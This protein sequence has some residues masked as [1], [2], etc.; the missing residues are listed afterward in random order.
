MAWLIKIGLW[1]MFINYYPYNIMFGRFIPYG[2]YIFFGLIVIGILGSGRIRLDKTIKS[3]ILY[4]VASLITSVF[5]LSTGFAIES[6]VDFGIKIIV[7]YAVAHVCVREKSV[8]FAIRLLAGIA[9]LSAGAAY[10]QMGDIE[11]RLQLASGAAISINDFGSLMAYGCFAVIPLF[12]YSK[13]KSRFTIQCL[14]V[15]A[16]LLLVIEL[17]ISG[18]RKS[19]YA[20]IIL[21]LLLLVT[22][23]SKSKNRFDP[24]L[25]IGSMVLIAAVYLIYSNYLEQYVTQT[26]LYARILGEKAA[27]AEQSNEGRI[28]L[29]L[30]AWDDFKEHPIFGLGFRNFEYKHHIYTHSM[31]A[32]PLACSGLL[33]LLYLIPIFSMLKKQFNYATDKSQD[34]D[35]QVWNMELLAFYVV[36]L[37]IGIGIPYLYKEIPCIGFGLMIGWQQIRENEL[38]NS[39]E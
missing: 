13:I 17:F 9:I 27:M 15:A 19:F 4:A 35:I 33:S 39:G 24:A 34:N 38:Y 2:T 12:K 30:S 22:V 6:L 32:E 16:S 26:S 36:F 18:S 1:G 25:I 31:Y 10:L 3:W 5:A 29:Y 21:Y 11:A 7:T 37:F 28:G 14:T 20:V 23:V 8:S